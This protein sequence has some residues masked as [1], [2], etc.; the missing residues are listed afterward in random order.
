M[1][2][3]KL[4]T[5]VDGIGRTIIG[6]VTDES[7]ATLVVKNPA[8]V[9]VIPNQQTGQISVQ[10]IPFFF[11]EFAKQD[12]ELDVTWTFNRDLL[13]VASGLDLDDRLVS[14]YDNM[15]SVIAT[16]PSSIITPGDA[17]NASGN[18]NKVVKLFD[19]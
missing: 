5:F 9:H 4:T 13:T 19:D 18:Q 6:E 7:D 11:K 17:A 1:S 3:L 8:I 2:K 15:Y 14:Q 16:P 10:L 12:A